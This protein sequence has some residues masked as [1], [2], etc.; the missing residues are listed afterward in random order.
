MIIIYVSLGN[1]YK[2]M[3]YMVQNQFVYS[4]NEDD[5]VCRNSSNNFYIKLNF[6]KWYNQ[7]IEISSNKMKSNMHCKKFSSIALKPITLRWIRTGSQP[8]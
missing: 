7:R 3:K 8:D 6:E 4:R 5:S 2:T 1:V